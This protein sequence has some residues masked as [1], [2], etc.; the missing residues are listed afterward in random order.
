[1]HTRSMETRSESTLVVTVNAL[2]AMLPLD[3]TVDAN[4]NITEVVG[5][6]GSLKAH[7]R[8]SPFGG[9]VESSGDEAEDNPWRFNT[10]Y[11]DEE[12]GL[13]AYTFRYYD[14][15]TGRFLNRDPIG[16]EGGLTESGYGLMFLE[17][18]EEFK[19]AVVEAI[20]AAGSA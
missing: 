17:P 7:Y 5:D 12:T 3:V 6:D 18:D 13:Y 20:S 2:S 10:Q 19:K 4:G 11:F 14:P 1:M 8:Y 16:E 9:V 15:E